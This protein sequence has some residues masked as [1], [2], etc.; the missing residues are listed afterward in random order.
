MVIKCLKK[1][2]KKSYG[3]TKVDLHLIQWQ[4]GSP[5]PTELGVF[6]GSQLAEVFGVGLWRNLVKGL[7]EK[8]SWAQS[9]AVIF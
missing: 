5:G 8:W 4:E 3:S 1:S 7:P 9:S 6:E 2:P